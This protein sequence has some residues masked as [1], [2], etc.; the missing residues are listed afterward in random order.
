VG[1]GVGE[2][3]GVGVSSGVGDGLGVD[4]GLVVSDG[5]CDRVG[6]SEDEDGIGV[7]A[8][9][10]DGVGVGELDEDNVIVG[11]SVDSDN[12]DRST[13]DDNDVGLGV[14]SD[15]VWLDVTSVRKE[16]D[17]D[18]ADIAALLETLIRL[19]AIEEER[20]ADDSLKRVVADEI[21]ESEVSELT[22]DETD[23]ERCVYVDDCVLA[24]LEDEA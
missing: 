3:V 7:S 17:R 19:V 24:R 4:D 22:K 13:D 14:E 10:K 16:L 11:E 8:L 9:D 6:S 18:E 2:G 5:D 1:W 23:E 15:D 12:V 20:S 21:D